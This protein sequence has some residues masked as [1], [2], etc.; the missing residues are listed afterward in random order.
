MKIRHRKHPFYHTLIEDYANEY[1]LQM[2]TKEISGYNKL[3]MRAMKELLGGGSDP[4]HEN[5]LLE[6]K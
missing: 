2:I 1:E 3:E 4:H 6:N 5:L